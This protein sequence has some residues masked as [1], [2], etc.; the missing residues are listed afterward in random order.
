MIRLTDG[1]W[2]RIRN[3]F[4]EE[5]IPDGRPGRK[6]V[7]T[8]RVLE[9]V[10]W[11]LNTVRSGTCCRKAIRTTKPYIGAF[12]SESR[13]LI[14]SLARCLGVPNP[15]ISRI[16]FELETWIGKRGDRGC[17]FTSWVVRQSVG[18]HL[19]G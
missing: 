10:L 8:R 12:A 14:H 13:P 15:I 16:L 6:P 9:A 2:E 3:H 1:Q 18:L 4:P 17:P 19:G 7:A 5:N 11:I